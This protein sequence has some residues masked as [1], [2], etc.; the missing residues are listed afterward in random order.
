MAQDLWKVYEVDG[1]FFFDAQFQGEHDTRQT[2]GP[3]TDRGQAEQELAE[4]DA[5]WG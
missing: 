1:Q 3:Y 5:M 4:C 2:F